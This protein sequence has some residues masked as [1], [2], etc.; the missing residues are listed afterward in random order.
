MVIDKIEIDYF[1]N[2]I[3]QLKRDWRNF[4][5]GITRK[6]TILYM[7]KDGKII[8]DK[9]NQLE[10]LKD[11]AKIFL[12]KEIKNKKISSNDLMIKK[13]FIGDYLKDI[14]DDLKNKDIQSWQYNFNL[15]LIFL[16]EFFCEINKIPLNKPKYLME[17]IAK[18]DKEFI[19]IYKSIAKSSSIKD[20]SQKINKLSSYCLNLSGGKLP[21]EWEIRG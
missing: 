6:N 19:R 3:R 7:L 14:E 4:K 20:K 11:E 18:K 1:V 5:K 17:E 15:L 12:K 21:K 16:V 8:S 10:K 9:N 2:S 13:Y